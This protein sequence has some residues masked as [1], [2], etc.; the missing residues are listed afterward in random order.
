M[1]PHA[2]AAAPPRT[3]SSERLLNRALG[4]RQ[5]AALI[6]NETVGSGI[7]VM[8]ALA[9]ADLGAAAILAYLVCAVVMALM[10][11]CFAEAGSRVSATGGP[12][13][14]VETA[15]GPL[16]GFLVGVLLQISNLAAAAAVAVL[17]A[18]SVGALIGA[19]SPLAL[20]AIALVV[21]AVVAIINIHGVRDGAR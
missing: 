11:L 5:L 21:L 3:S 4:V 17:F 10:V 7:F 2:R 15:L 19:P 12:Y 8:P 13:A 16:V 6:F 20:D 1:P 14:Y 9:A 18:G